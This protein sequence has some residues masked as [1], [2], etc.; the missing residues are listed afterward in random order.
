MK[1]IENLKAIMKGRAGTLTGSKFETFDF[2]PSRFECSLSGLSRMGECADLFLDRYTAGDLEE[3]IGRTGLRDHLAAKG[4]PRLHVTGEKNEE[5]MHSLRVYAGRPSPERLLID[6]R[7]SEIIYIPDAKLI[8]GIIKQR[9]YRALAIEWLC[10]QNPGAKFT[11]EFP[12]LPGQVHP[13]VGAVRYIAPLLKHF[14]RDL[15]FEAALDVPEHFH[16]AVMYSR[17]F[18]FMD[19][20]KE[21]LMRAA[22]RDLGSVSLSDLSWGFLTGA[23]LNAATKEPVPYE[24]S[25]QIMPFHD[26]LARYFSSMKYRK[27]VDEAMKAAEYIFDRERMLQKKSHPDYMQ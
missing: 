22:L 21:G 25:E 15:S 26:G 11:P 7:L 14:A 3:I 8:P 18:R 16:A 23:V 10:F 12:R 19:P 2:S 27:R 1:F 17:T 20:R 5:Q 24:P 4:F 6:I 9:R 13:G